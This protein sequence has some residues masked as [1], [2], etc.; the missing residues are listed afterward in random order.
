MAQIYYI[1]IREGDKHMSDVPEH[2]KAQVQV[3]LDKDA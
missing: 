1:L 2:L 3:L